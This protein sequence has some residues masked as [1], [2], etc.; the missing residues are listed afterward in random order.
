VHARADTG[1]DPDATTAEAD[2]TTTTCLRDLTADRGGE[3]EGTDYESKATVHGGSL[4][5]SLVT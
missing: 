5:R 1:G 2:P 4:S 3:D